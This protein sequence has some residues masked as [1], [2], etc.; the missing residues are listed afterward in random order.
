[1]KEIKSKSDIIITNEDIN[2]CLGSNELLPCPF[3]GHKWPMSFGERTPNGKAI[4]WKVQCTRTTGSLVPDCCA[5]VWDTQK[6][7]NQARKNA[8]AK[9]NRRPV[10]KP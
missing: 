9:W 2:I 6:D 8:V 5:S 1:M 4:C 10:S 7:Q 3:C